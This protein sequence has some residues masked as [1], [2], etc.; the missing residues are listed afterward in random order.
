MN[1][2]PAAAQQRRYSEADLSE[3]VFTRSRTRWMTLQLDD[4][5]QGP[6]S[7]G[8]PLNQNQPP[9]VP[10]TGNSIY[11][12]TDAVATHQSQAAMMPPAAVGDPAI[13]PGHTAPHLIDAVHTPS[14]SV[15]AST[16]MARLSS[17]EQTSM[18]P[19]STLVPGQTAVDQNPF[20]S[21]RRIGHPKTL[22]PSTDPGS[23]HSRL[24]GFLV[25]ELWLPHSPAISPRAPIS[26]SR[27][28]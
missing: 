26:R 11:F 1:D 9:N 24:P 28:P 18:H 14:H 2:N 21:A 3:G 16:L 13:M 17:Q 4:Q 8:Q 5:S 22:S 23:T 25:G 12:T 20:Q 19:T 15:P 6:S 10:F 7:H 27:T